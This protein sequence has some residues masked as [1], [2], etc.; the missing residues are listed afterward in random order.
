MLALSLLFMA[1]A[2]LA[3]QLRFHLPFT[4]VPFTGQVLVVLLAGFV[5]GRFGVVSMGLYLVMGSCL[6][7][8]S[9]AVGLAAL[10]GVTAGYLF[11]FLVAAALIGEMAQRRREWSMA[12]I[13]AV[14]ALG[15]AAILLLGSWWLSA[16]LGIGMAEALLIGAVPFLAVDALKIAVASSIAYG[17]TPRPARAQG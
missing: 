10:S 7:W 11:G 17:L 2:G 3:A 9:G 4:P 15:D 16:L 1:L 12:R 5:L 8:F 6:G 14:M 13:V